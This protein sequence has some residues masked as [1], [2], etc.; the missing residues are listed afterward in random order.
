MGLS[1]GTQEDLTRAIHNLREYKKGNVRT[2]MQL[3]PSG[4][5]IFNVYSYDAVIAWHT[6]ERGWV[7]ND[8]KYSVTTSHHQNVVRAAIASDPMEW[9]FTLYREDDANVHG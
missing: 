3:L 2:E 4:R 1:R 5:C 9:L 6:P 7:F 8:R